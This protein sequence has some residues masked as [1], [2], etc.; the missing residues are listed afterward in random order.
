[1]ITEEQ[2]K[3]AFGVIAGILGDCHDEL[4]DGLPDGSNPEWGY[5]S[6]LVLDIA[7]AC[8][9]WTDRQKEVVV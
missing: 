3:V 8:H 5:D 4:A 7:Q 1:M 6:Q 2:L 9:N